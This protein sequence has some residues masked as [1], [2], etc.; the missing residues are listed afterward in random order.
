MVTD[1]ITVIPALKI[2]NILFFKLLMKSIEN[3]KLLAV[4]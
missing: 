3:Y 2:K 1:L 4:A